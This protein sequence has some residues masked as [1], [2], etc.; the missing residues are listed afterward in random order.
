MNCGFMD[1]RKLKFY[2]NLNFPPKKYYFSRITIA[3]YRG[4][5]EILYR[6]CLNL[7]KKL[8]LAKQKS[9]SRWQ[10]IT[11]G[12]LILNLKDELANGE[13]SEYSSKSYSII[14]DVSGYMY[15]RLRT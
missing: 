5:T 13:R 6:P 1:D 2:G 4:N 8:K 10:I 11:F 3:V 9:L 7:A 15:Y 14:G 12:W